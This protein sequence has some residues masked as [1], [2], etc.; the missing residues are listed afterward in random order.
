MLNRMFDSAVLSIGVCDG[1]S[2]CVCVCVIVSVCVS[3]VMCTSVM[4][5]ESESV[6]H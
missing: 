2:N 6:C 5:C 4:M 1:K 3:N